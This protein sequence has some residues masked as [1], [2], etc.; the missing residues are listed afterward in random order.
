[1]VNLWLTVV[2]L[3]AI[4]FSLEKIRMLSQFILLIAVVS[5]TFLSMGFDLVS[6]RRII[7]LSSLSE[8]KWLPSV[9][10]ATFL[11]NGFDASANLQRA[12]VALMVIAAAWLMLNSSAGKRYPILLDKLDSATEKEARSPLSL[13]LLVYFR[14]IPLVGRLGV[15]DQSFAVASLILS[16]TQ[17][18]E[19]S[20]VKLF[21][22]RVLMVVFLVVSV[23]TKDSY[24]SAFLMTYFSFTAVIEGVDIIRHNTYASASWIFRALP[25]SDREMLRGMRAAIWLKCYLL[26]GYLMLVAFFLIHP[27]D[28]A[29]AMVILNF[30][31]ASILISMLI[32]I[33]PALPLSREQPMSLGLMTPLISLA[34]SVLN[35]IGF[36][37]LAFSLSISPVIGW[38][39]AS[40]AIAALAATSYALNSLAASRLSALEAG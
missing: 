30:I 8:V 3:A 11:T 5:M 36:G 39:I 17:R 38:I 22:P 16:A 4:R 24:I 19:T 20:R 7:S 25:V 1:M 28:V 21:L 14:R 33:A 35:A 18:E 23:V 27:P 15:S 34:A 37:V 40:V 13:R 9:W 29:C 31:Q 6:E 26:P 12:G 10:F 2:L 32:A